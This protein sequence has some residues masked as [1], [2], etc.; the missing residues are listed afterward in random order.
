M[1]KSKKMIRSSA[2]ALWVDDIKKEEPWYLKS[3]SGVSALV[4]LS[5][6]DTLGFIQG[7][8]SCLPNLS[9]ASSNEKNLTTFSMVVMVIGF[10]AAFEGAT[11]YMAYA[12][13]LRLYNY[14]RCALQRASLAGKNIK[15]SRFVSTDAL[16][17]W[18]FATFLLG[19]LANTI[20]RIG[21]FFNPN[22]TAENRI[23]NITITIVMILLPIITSMLNFVIGCFTFDPLIFEL[24]YLA[25]KITKE[26]CD[27]DYL[28][29][30][31]SSMKLEKEKIASLKETQTKMRD[32][33]KECVKG[34]LPS[35]CTRIYEETLWN[36]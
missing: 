21:I 24:S 16:G 28:H 25:K 26:E 18:C 4:A 22:T 5:I 35:L 23:I 32:A 13:S 20:F 33:S 1:S 11:L 12:F 2:E 34:L 30:Q 15:L 6:L 31:I 10:I 19:V 36:V 29:N 27:I 8:L 9:T 14:D 17:W 7:A 3:A